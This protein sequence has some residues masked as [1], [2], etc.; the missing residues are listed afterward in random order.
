MTI[1]CT[2]C[3]DTFWVCESSSGDAVGVARPP[4]AAAAAGVPCPACNV[5]AEGERPRLPSGFTPTL[6]VDDP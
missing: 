5:P 4:A 1:T 6:D 2:V 3:Q